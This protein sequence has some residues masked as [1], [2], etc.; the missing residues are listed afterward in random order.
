MVET[1]STLI[2][3]DLLA[4]TLSPEDRSLI[5]LRYLHDFDANELAA[6]TDMTP[7]AVRQR[8]SRARRKLLDAVSPD[9]G[10]R[11]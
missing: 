2:V 9:P 5:V 10:G 6:M 7:D 8:L 4:R 3:R 1:D 11:P